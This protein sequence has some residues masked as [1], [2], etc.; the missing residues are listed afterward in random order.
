MS[1]REPI[2]RRTYD[3]QLYTHTHANL[4]ARLEKLLQYDDTDSTS[5]ERNFRECQ[6]LCDELQSATNED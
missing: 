6:R 1:E 3:D 5:F 4:L 2:L